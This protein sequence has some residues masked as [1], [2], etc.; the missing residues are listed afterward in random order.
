MRSFIYALLSGPKPS[1]FVSRAVVRNAVVGIEPVQVAAYHLLLLTSHLNASNR[2]E[3]DHVF[4]M[5]NNHE[6]SALFKYE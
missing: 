2:I 3:P 5:M 4:S 1:A 6:N